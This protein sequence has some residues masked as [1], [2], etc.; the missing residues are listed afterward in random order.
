M[1]KHT[2]GPWRRGNPT[3]VVAPITTSALAYANG[4]DGRVASTETGHRP[5]DERE[6]NARRIVLAVNCHDDLLAALRAMVDRWEP[7]SEGTDRTMWENA[8][9]AITKASP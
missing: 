1:S 9:A 3:L 2:P 7:D 5:K 6:A 8:V 4:T